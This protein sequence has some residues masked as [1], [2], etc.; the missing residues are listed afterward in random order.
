MSDT[1]GVVADPNSPSFWWV[2]PSGEGLSYE[3]LKQR[4][5]IAAA[6]ASRSR[7]YPTTI[8]QGIASVG[9]SVGD[10][11]YQK[12]TDA[13][14][15]QQRALD[16]A[17]KAEA[18]GAGASVVTPSPVG[19]RAAGSVDAG[20]VLPGPAS[21]VAELPP[22]VDAGRAA[23]TQSAMANPDL[24]QMAA[25]NTG[26]MSDAGQPGATYG[27]PAPAGPGAPVA[28]RPDTAPPDTS[29]SAGRDAM[30]PSLMAQAGQRGN[31]EV[32]QPMPTTPA[33]GTLRQPPAAPA[34]PPP[35]TMP[36]P[37]QSLTNEPPATGAL[38]PQ[39]KI[40]VDTPEMTRIKRALDSPKF[41]LMSPGAREEL[42][43]QLKKYKEARDKQDEQKMEQWKKD[44]SDAQDRRKIEQERRFGQPK[45]QREAT[46]AMR[47]ENIGRVY[48]D[49]E[50]HKTLIAEVSKRGAVAR[51]L[52]ENLPVLYEAEKMLKDKVIVA[53]SYADVGPSLMNNPWTG[54]IG[55][56]SVMDIK[57]MTPGVTGWTGVSNKEQVVNT[58]EFQA[59]LR[60]LIGAMAKKISPTGSLSN[61]EIG[62]AAAAIGIK[63]NLEQES[64][65]KIIQNLKR[66]AFASIAN[67]NALM[68]KTLHPEID[69]KVIDANRAEI[70]PDPEDVSNLRAT[71]N[72]PE[73]RARFDHIYGAGSAR[74]IL[75]YGR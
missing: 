45:E 58:E 20:P 71:P 12:Q 69:A 3:Q 14:E 74:K 28:E 52:A 70:T 25:L 6:L 73:E 15:R 44:Y 22:D 75:G 17:A 36:G 54:P 46:E 60:P 21:A 53:G 10:A 65:L 72:S 38:P 19:G 27:G 24:V 2:N 47:K 16:R 7:P 30:V 68:R 31:V 62:Q 64:M 48:G 42:N 43:D 63:P 35:T 5:A 32:R 41:E 49:P 26:T 23:V 40:G 29:I 55:L 56:P 37:G 67:H 9:E 50:T 39:P 59:K 1:S 34:T 8:G 18:R 66:E 57:K 11:I 33:A 4:R 51:E 13:Y 61:M